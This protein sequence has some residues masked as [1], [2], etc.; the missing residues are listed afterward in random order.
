MRDEE[1]RIPNYEL[2]IENWAFLNSE[3]G[4]RYSQ[5]FGNPIL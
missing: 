4:I 1:L 2:R 5:F 3:F